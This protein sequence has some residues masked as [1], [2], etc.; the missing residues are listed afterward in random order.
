MG[1]IA[2]KGGILKE[3]D[4]IFESRLLAFAKTFSVAEAMA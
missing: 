3:K 4:G 1:D 2:G